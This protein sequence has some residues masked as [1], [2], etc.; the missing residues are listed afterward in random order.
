VFVWIGNLDASLY[1]DLQCPG[2]NSNVVASR[3]F[4]EGLFFFQLK[5]QTKG[6]LGK[7]KD[8]QNDFLVLLYFQVTVAS[9]APDNTKLTELK[10]GKKSVIFTH[11]PQQLVYTFSLFLWETHT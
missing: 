4:F 8:K 1:K 10:N 7:H 6:Q 3:T 11:Q 9:C 2:L 5:T